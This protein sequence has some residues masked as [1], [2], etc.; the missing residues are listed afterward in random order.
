MRQDSFDTTTMEAAHVSA[1]F[2]QNIVTVLPKGHKLHFVNF[3]GEIKK[4]FYKNKF[5]V[6]E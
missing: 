5:H 4:L 6:Y 3:T 2:K 1:I